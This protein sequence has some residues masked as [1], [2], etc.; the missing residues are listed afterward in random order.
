MRYFAMPKRNKGDF[1]KNYQ[2]EGIK[3]SYPIGTR[4]V[5]DSMGDDPCQIPGGTKGTVNYVDSL[6]TIH[7]TFDNGRH[8]GICPDVDSFHQITDH[9]QELSEDMTMEMSM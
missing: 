4:I 1:M 7:T 5:L 2:I 3:K 6:G 8:L 9:E